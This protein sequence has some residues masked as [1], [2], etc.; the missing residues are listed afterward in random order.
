[1][2]HLKRI[3]M[4]ALMCAAASAGAQ[5]PTYVQAVPI[6]PA[7]IDRSA[8][9]CADFNAF[10][11]GGWAKRTVIPA[12]FSRWGSFDE[13]GE[14][15]QASLQAIL[16]D[17]TNP[18]GRKLSRNEHIV[19][20]YYT[21]CMDSALAEKQGAAP[22]WPTLRRIDA[23]A[24]RNQLQ[25][26]VARLHLQ[27]VQ[28]IFGFGATQD[29]KN[30]ESVIGGA[31]QGGLSL[32]SRDYYIENTAR[33]QQIRKDY[34][35]HIQ[36]MLGL[37][38]VKPAA[39]AVQAQSILA[40][41]TALA[42]ASLSNVELRD[43]IKTYNRRTPAELAKLTPH[44]NW[45]HYFADIGA[46]K[47]P[48][49][50]VQNPNFMKAVD[51]LL[52]AVPMADWKAYLRWKAVRSYAGNLSSQFV[53]E[54]FAFDSKLTGAKEQLPRYKRCTRA[55]DAGL[56]DGLGRIYV[57]KN[58]TPEAKA[59]ALE[60]INHLADVYRERINTLPWMSPDTRKQAIVKLNTYVRKIGYPD[61]W[62][63]YS[64][65]TIR[66]GAYLP[67]RIA[68][69]VYENKRDLAQIGKPVNR[70]D[71]GMTTPTVNAYYNPAMNEIVFPAGIMQPPFF[72]PKADDA[73]NYGGMGAVIGHEISHGFD[74]QGSQFDEKG[75]L[76]NWWTESD[77]KNFKAKTQLV[78]SQFSGYTVLDS[79]H[80]IGD[81]TLGENIADLG[82][83]SVA[84][85][86]LQKALAEK[87]RPGLIDGYT[88]EQRF[89]LAWAQI[90]RQSMR[91]ELQRQ[92][93]LTD[94]HSPAIW[95]T[96][97]PLSNLPEFAQAF[98]CKPGDPM[99]RGDSIRAVIW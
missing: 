81:L 70:K 84:Y 54:A 91:P 47:V 22:L 51:S 16:K 29:A 66:R 68:T 90:W 69:T 12:A 97:G 67:N 85:A 59:R 36:R 74:D 99:V 18:N 30:S 60:M 1:M 56:R 42:K 6:D 11:N 3:A 83:L 33:F 38:G 23:I 46:P 75:N 19:A 9:A 25:S 82:G 86:A 5:T 62:R 21:S 72:D 10:A 52:V 28:A 87:G 7:N 77:Q 26:Q 44:F 4:A 17:I 50:D 80:V 45:T 78:S 65:L 63:D 58:F 57:E 8:S 55:T 40:I 48:A 20:D 37:V 73:V 98:G 61:V 89:F 49:V 93:I 71:W 41:E 43:P 35:D 39:A 34:V 64:T 88:P 94:P 2:L 96:N 79:V 92:R 15:N 53:N 76:R 31:V 32:P 95:R 14:R 13:L 27:G 24:N